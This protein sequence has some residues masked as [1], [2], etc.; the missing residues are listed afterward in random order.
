MSELKLGDKVHHKANPEF[1]MVV[2]DFDTMWD[3]DYPKS[4]KNIKNP[5]HPYCKYYNVHTNK[6]EQYLFKDYE[7]E[8]DED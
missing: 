7:L 5:A 8:A 6:W 1:K 2:V 4:G 3:N